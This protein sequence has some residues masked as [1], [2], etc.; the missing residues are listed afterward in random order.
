MLVLNDISTLPIKA[1]D[2]NSGSGSRSAEHANGEVRAAA[3]TD[4]EAAR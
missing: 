1:D 3:S 2:A 4:T